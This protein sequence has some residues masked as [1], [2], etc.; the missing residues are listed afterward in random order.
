[1]A[2]P[3]SANVVEGCLQFHLGRA[4]DRAGHGSHEQVAQG[5]RLGLCVSSCW[6]CGKQGGEGGQGGEA[7]SLDVSFF[8]VDLS[9]SEF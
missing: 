2:D 7:A 3:G 9:S 8:V 6:D 5:I 1:M 4:G